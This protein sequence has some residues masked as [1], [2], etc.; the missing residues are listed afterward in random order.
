[1]SSNENKTKGLREHAEKKRVETEFKVDQ[2]IDFMMKS[3]ETVINFQT[4]SKASGISRT[5]LYN[6]ARIRKKI[7]ALRI[8]DD[9]ASKEEIIST[10]KEIERLKQELNRLMRENQFLADQLVEM[11]DIRRENKRLK[12][13]LS[14]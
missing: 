11:D 8:P 12:A 3:G 2:A 10:R 6:N 7:E 14:K 1:M 5:T 4:V 13:L 9:D